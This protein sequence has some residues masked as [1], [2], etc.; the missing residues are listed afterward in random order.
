MI[1]NLTQHNPSPEQMADGVVDPDAAL[2]I[3]PLLTIERDILVAPEPLRSEALD[4]RV[5]SIMGCLYRQLSSLRK[6]RM[7]HALAQSTDMA[8]DNAM[9][10]PIA[11]AMVGGASYLT[12][13]LVRRLRDAGVQPLYALSERVSEEVVQEDGST[14]KVS[15]FNHLGFIEAL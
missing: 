9:Q 10:E 7:E 11:D 6:E 13:R 3:Q 14:R 4:S 8:R 1:L 12:E 2:D 5:E 15:R